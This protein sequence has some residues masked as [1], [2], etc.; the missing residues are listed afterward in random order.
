V[1]ILDEQV[2]ESQRQLLRS[3][4]IPIHQI[5]QF[6]TLSNTL[7]QKPEEK[8]EKHGMIFPSLLPCAEWKMNRQFIPWMTLG[9]HLND[10]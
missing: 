9:N 7:K 2:I 1:N 10:L 6:S 4:R 3:W 5:G 8:K